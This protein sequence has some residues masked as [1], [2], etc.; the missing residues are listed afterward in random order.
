MWTDAVGYEEADDN[1]TMTDLHNL[2]V[3]ETQADLHSDRT[4]LYCTTH[5]SFDAL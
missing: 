5:I 1:S 3:R 4:L 2:Q